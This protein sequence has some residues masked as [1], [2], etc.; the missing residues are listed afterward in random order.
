[1]IGDYVTNNTKVFTIYY[2]LDEMEMDEL[3]EE[4]LNKCLDFILVGK[5]RNKSKDI[6]FGLQKLTEVALRAISPGINDPN[7]AIFC[8]KQAGMVLDRIAK[9]NI[10]NTYYYNEDNELT[11]IFEDI[12][13]DYLL[14]KTFYQLRYYSKRDVSVAASILEALI[15]IAEGN[16]QEIKDIT[17]EFGNYIVKGFDEEI[18]ED[19]DKKYMNGKIEELAVMTEKSKGSGIYFE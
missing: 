6:E 8:I 19:L 9:A 4:T 5:E 16:E 7:T 18:L 11:L 17:W 3:N 13:F 10:E 1:M 12:S 15:I 14:Y 2:N